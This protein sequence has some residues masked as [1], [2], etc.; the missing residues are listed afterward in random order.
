M[1]ELYGNQINELYNSLPYHMIEFSVDDCEWLA[2]SWIHM[3]L[4]L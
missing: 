3:I 4:L 1:N 2:I